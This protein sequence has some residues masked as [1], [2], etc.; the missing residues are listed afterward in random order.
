MSDIFP[1][2]RLAYY[3]DDFTGSTD[4]LEALHLGGVPAVLFLEPPTDPLAWREQFPQ[5]QAVGIAG[6]ARSLPTGAM[7]AE[8]APALDVLA[9]MK[10]EYFLYKL[11]STFDSSPEIGSIGRA[12]ELVRS[13]FP[14]T[15]LPLAVAAPFLRRHL[16][17]GNL[18]AGFGDEVMRL[19]RH[20]TMSRHPVTPMR[21][22]DLRYHLGQQTTLPSGLIDCLT[23]RAGADQ[24]Q[25]RFKAWADEGKER[26]IFIDTLDADD[27]HRVGRTL[28]DLKA[29][30]PGEF[31]LPI[32]GSSMVAQA[33]SWVWQQSEEAEITK[34]EPVS[35]TPVE[36]LV[37]MAGSASPQT[38][39]QIDAAAQAGWAM[40]RINVPDLINPDVT[41]SE[42]DRLAAEATRALQAGRSVVLYS[43]RGP[44]DPALVKEVR[45]G[46]VLGKEQGRLLRSILLRSGLRRACVA[47][48]DTSGHAARQL[49]IF[50]LEFAAV[51][52]PGAPLCRVHSV[53]ADFDGMELALKG[54]QSGSPDY[55]LKLENYP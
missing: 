25:A 32:A 14:A 1:Q 8:I 18:F 52:A 7:E 6:V 29:W 16:V 41:N 49:G 40:L 22:S 47:G 43:A 39:A 27:V 35:P 10:P 42:H 28:V 34:V 9:E 21:E 12:L 26:N 23:L 15:L 2:L 37:V 45:S 19:D 55:F 51:M 20:T 54:G 50:A 5:A 33:L 44:D 11:C 24:V 4:V 46:G 31:T 30:L 36:Q 3:G 38:A 13:R 53:D 17:F 48:G